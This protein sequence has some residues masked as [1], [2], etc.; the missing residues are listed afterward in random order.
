MTDC[1]LEC[2]HSTIAI[3][4]RTRSN[5]VKHFVYQ[6]LVCG[7]ELRSVGKNDP[8]ILALTDIIPFNEQLLTEW[9]EQRQNYWRQQAEQRRQDY[10]HEQSE[11]IRETEQRRNQQKAD[12]QA[13]YAQYLASPE[14]RH[15]RAAVL[16]RANGMCEGCLTRKATQV[17]HLTYAHVGNELLFE[18]VAICDTCHALAHANRDEVAA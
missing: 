9:Q 6:C 5:R 18:L 11:R 8:A 10:L 13:W 16:R 4:Q 2:D 17:H 15:K 3:R 12:W 14:R 7:A 1:T